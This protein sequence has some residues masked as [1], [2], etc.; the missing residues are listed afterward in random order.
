MLYFLDTVIVIYAV[1]GSLADQQR[2]GLATWPPL[3]WLAIVSR[4]VSS[5][6]PSVW[7]RFSG[8]A[9][10]SGFQTSSVSSAVQTCIRSN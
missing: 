6:K 1:E 5:F 7:L 8:R 2:A 10:A 9:K 4:S 3:S